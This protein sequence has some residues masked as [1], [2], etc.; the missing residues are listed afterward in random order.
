MATAALG[1]LGVEFFA[2]AYYERPC[3]FITSLLQGGGRRFYILNR[4]LK[5]VAF[6]LLAQEAIGEE[7]RTVCVGFWRL[8]LPD[9]ISRRIADQFLEE[10]SAVSGGCACV[11]FWRGWDLLVGAAERQFDAIRSP[12]SGDEKDDRNRTRTDGGRAQRHGSD[13]HQVWRACER[14]VPAAELPSANGREEPAPDS[15]EEPP[16]REAERQVEEPATKPVSEPTA[17]KPGKRE[18]EP[19]KSKDCKLEYGGYSI[20]VPCR[21]L[22]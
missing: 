19:R 21:A 7:P 14:T 20:N 17:E 22:E 11:Y 6:Q 4:S 8:W 5:L 10:H 3:T 13:Y 2:N 1:L 18:G 15:T 16:R 9:P 12:A